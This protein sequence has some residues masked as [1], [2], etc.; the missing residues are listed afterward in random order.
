MKNNLGFS[1]ACGLIAYIIN[2]IIYGSLLN[3][4]GAFI[5]TF[6]ACMVLFM[7]IDWLGY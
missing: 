5:T 4:L 3:G 7:I 1:T 6:F 2:V